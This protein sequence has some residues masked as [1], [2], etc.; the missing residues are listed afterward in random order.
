MSGIPSHDLEKGGAE[1]FKDYRPISLVGSLYKLL[2]KV[3]ANRLKRVMHKL[4]S[5]CSGLSSSLC[6][7][8]VYVPRLL[9]WLLFL[10]NIF[11]RLPIK[12]KIYCY[13]DCIIYLFIIISQTSIRSTE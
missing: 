7:L 11:L 1:D 2:A 9:A 8:P 13:F 12:N 4:I 3:L 5:F 10:S 6:I